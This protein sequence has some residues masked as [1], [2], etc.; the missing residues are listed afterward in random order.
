MAI[1]FSIGFC[2]PFAKMSTVRVEG[3]ESVEIVSADGD[4]VGV[5]IEDPREIL[6]LDE[7]ITTLNLDPDRMWARLRADD[8]VLIGRRQATWG[9]GGA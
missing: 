7:L 1:Y 5:R 2:Q 6:R 8:D 4:I 3:F 9:G